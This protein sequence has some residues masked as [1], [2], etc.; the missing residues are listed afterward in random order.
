MQI[1]TN[2]SNSNVVSN[3]QTTTTKASNRTQKRTSQIQKPK[4]KVLMRT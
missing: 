2:K 3:Q 4:K 1:L